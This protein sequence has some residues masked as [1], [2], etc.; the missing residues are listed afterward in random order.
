MSSSNHSCCSNKSPANTDQVYVDQVGAIKDP[1]CGMTVKPDSPLRHEH[2]GILYFFC[3]ERCLKKFAAEPA[4]FLGERSAPEPVP[5]AQYTC[6]MHPE[7]IADGPD[8]CPKCGM[9][10]EPMMPALEE[11]ENPELTDFR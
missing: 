6:P 3:G 9:A 11:E 1:V 10:L 7:V 4:Q 5:G 2:D 8:T